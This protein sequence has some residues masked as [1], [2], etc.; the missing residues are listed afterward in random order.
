MQHELATFLIKCDASGNMIRVYWHQPVYLISPFQSTIYD[1]FDESDKAI[2]ETGFRSVYEASDQPVNHQTLHLLSPQKKIFVCMMKSNQDVLLMGLDEGIMGTQ[3]SADK[4]Q[5]F[6]Q[7]FMLLM[8]RS[9]SSLNIQNEKTIREQFE[10]IQMLNNQLINIQRQLSKAN[11]ELNRLN[12]YLNNRLVKDELTGLV[13]R[14][15]YRAEIDLCIN[16]QPDKQGIF[17]FIDIDHF[18]AINDTHGHQVGDEFLKAFARRLQ[19]VEFANKICMRISGDEFGLYIHGYTA[20]N[21]CDINEIWYELKRK[22][23]AQNVVVGDISLPINFSAGMAIYGNDTNQVYD[24][25]EYADFAM[26][27]AKRNGKNSHCRFDLDLYHR[28]KQK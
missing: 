26:Y 10:Q 11:S 19:R 16:S 4:I 25:I 28:D 21:D 22:I 12:S 23:I 24:L 15:Q 1:L 5:Y 8:N 20:V 18:K 2:I 6:M 17:T 9:D 3:D 13:S 14:Y 7:E 27:Q